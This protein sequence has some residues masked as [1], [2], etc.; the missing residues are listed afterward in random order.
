M[1]GT[2]SSKLLSFVEQL[3]RAMPVSLLQRWYERIDGGSR[4][5]CSIFV[6]TV[7]SNFTSVGRI[8]ELNLDHPFPGQRLGQEYHDARAILV[9]ICQKSNLDDT[10]VVVKEAVSPH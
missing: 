7:Y 6:T 9:L 5:V 8:L 3:S 2:G 1:D 10:Q 4:R